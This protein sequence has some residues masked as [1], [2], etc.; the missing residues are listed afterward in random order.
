LYRCSWLRIDRLTRSQ[1][2]DRRISIRLLAPQQARQATSDTEYDDRNQK[3]QRH[4]GRR[5]GGF[6]LPLVPQPSHA[7]HVIVATPLL[8]GTPALAPI[9]IIEIVRIVIVAPRYCPPTVGF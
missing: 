9:Q 2:P 5:A 7:L 3:H 4:D 8:L 1:K 6:S